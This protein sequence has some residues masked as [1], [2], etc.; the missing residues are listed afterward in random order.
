MRAWPLATI[1]A[2]A[3]P[4]R[5]HARAAY[6]GVSRGGRG[7][8]CAPRAA[9]LVLARAQMEGGALSPSLDAAL[10]SVL[11]IPGVEHVLISSGFGLPVARVSTAPPWASDPAPLEAHFA[12][13][14]AKAA[15]ALDRLA[16]EAAA[17]AAAAA[18]ARAPPTVIATVFTSFV[19]VQA[20]LAPLVVAAAARP[21]VDVARLA[22]ALPALAAV[23]EPLREAS[24]AYGNY[25]N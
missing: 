8:A 25:G 21:A 24:E 7:V 1:S 23:L 15:E 6:R 12:L 16:P 22:A 20:S 14:F 17:A 2:C 9:R 18:A 19:L 11:A 13:A 10:R 5:V 3:L 4:L